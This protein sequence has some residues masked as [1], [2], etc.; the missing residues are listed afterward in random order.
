MASGACRYRTGLG[1]PIWLNRDPIFEAGGINLYGFVE[2]APIGSID[3]FGLEIPPPPKDMGFTLPDVEFAFRLADM[4]GIKGPDGKSLL[5]V[6]A[7]MKSSQQKINWVERDGIPETVNAPGACTYPCNPTIRFPKSDPDSKTKD[8]QG[9]G[10]SRFYFPAA[11]IH[12]MMHAYDGMMGQVP[13]GG[14]HEREKE[15]GRIGNELNKCIDDM[16]KSSQQ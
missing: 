16:I 3:P 15:P 6:L 10:N 8:I 13:I 12:E 2:N 11:L 4:C 9:T 14:E 1:H 7:E 5:T